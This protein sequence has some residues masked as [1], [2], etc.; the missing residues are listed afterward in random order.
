MGL[1]SIFLVGSGITTVGGD[2][3]RPGQLAALSLGCRAGLLILSLK[4]RNRFATGGG[5]SRHRLVM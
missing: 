4:S 2:E 5:V 1:F 3:H